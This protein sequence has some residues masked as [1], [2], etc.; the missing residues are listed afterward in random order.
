MG[1]FA[2]RASSLWVARTHIILGEGPKAN[3]TRYINH[4]SARQNAELVV[5]T[6]WK[7]TQ[8]AAIRTIRAGDEMR[9]FVEGGGSFLRSPS[10]LMHALDI[11]ATM[12][13]RSE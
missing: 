10:I 9:G 1:A 4:N 2:T 5:S 3:Y 7:T 11:S 8:F 12:S 13:G 6:W